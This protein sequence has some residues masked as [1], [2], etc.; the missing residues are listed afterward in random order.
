MGVWKTIAIQTLFAIF[1][2]LA[3][4]RVLFLSLK[5]GA[6]VGGKWGERYSKTEHPVIYWFCVGAYGFLFACSIFI[7]AVVIRGDYLLVNWLKPSN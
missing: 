3:T 1:L 7:L 6:V 4:S 2:V 5:Y